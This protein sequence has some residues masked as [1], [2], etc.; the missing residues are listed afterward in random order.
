M[1][2]CDEYGILEEFNRVC[3]E[4]SHNLQSYIKYGQLDDQTVEIPMTDIFPDIDGWWN[5]DFLGKNFMEL[6]IAQLQELKNSDPYEYKNTLRSRLDLLGQF[7]V[8]KDQLYTL[9]K[10][11]Q[12]PE[13]DIIRCTPH[14]VAYALPVLL[15][16][17]GFKAF[18]DRVKKSRNLNLDI[19]ILP[20]SD[21]KNILD[22]GA[23]QL[24][25]YITSTDG[26]PIKSK[27]KKPSVRLS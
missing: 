11:K 17:N 5:L 25:A 13:P 24:V 8:L 18:N 12:F 15:E 16:L 22:P 2:I 1:I 4:V 3:G 10:N 23:Y 27:F 20:T 7:P 21:A 19:A 6:Q 9:I 14:N 26:K